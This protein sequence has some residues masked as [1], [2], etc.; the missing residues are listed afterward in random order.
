MATETENTNER[1]IV[2]STEAETRFR[3]DDEGTGTGDQ[4]PL[5]GPPPA[6]IDIETGDAADDSAES[7]EAGA[8]ESEIPVRRRR[9]RPKGSKNRPRAEPTAS[10]PQEQAP[11]APTP[12]IAGVDLSKLDLATI[13]CNILRSQN[14]VAEKEGWPIKWPEE[15]ITGL[16]HPCAEVIAEQ[17]KSAVGEKITPGVALVVISVPVANIAAMHVVSAVKKK[18]AKASDGIVTPIRRVAPPSAPE[19]EPNDENEEQTEPEAPE[20]PMRRG[21]SNKAA[22]AQYKMG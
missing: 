19:P 11:S 15:L 8:P 10:A 4:T 6:D 3:R 5:D 2:D 1:P 18:K 12:A 20:P 17:V 22:P 16:F 7:E 21:R 9:G 14:E 13:Y